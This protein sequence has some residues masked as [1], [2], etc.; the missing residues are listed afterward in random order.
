MRVLW[1]HFTI[2]TRRCNRKTRELRAKVKD[3]YTKVIQHYA[4][5]LRA[6]PPSSLGLLAT[7]GVHMLAI[8]KADADSVTVWTAQR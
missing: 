5:L 7:R 2:L 3:K 6:V 8:V 4:K 1:S